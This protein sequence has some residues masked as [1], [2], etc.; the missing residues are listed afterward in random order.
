MLN[1][2]WKEGVVNEALALPYRRKTFTEIK[3]LAKL[4]QVTV[5]SGLRRAGKSTLMY[6]LIQDL[7]QSG[8]K[9]EKILYFSFDEKAESLL[10]LLK[11]YSDFT[12]VDWKKENCLLFLDEIQKL[13]DWSSKLK[14]IYDA[15]P[16]LK[17]IV[18]GSSSFQLEKEAKANLAGRHFVVDVEPLSFEEYLELKKS[19]IDLSKAN[20][21]EAEIIKEFNEYLLK[22]FPEIVDYTELSLVK[23]YIKDNVLEKVLRIDLPKKFRNVNEE[24]LT[25]LVDLFY[26]TPGMYLNYDELARDLRTS[27]KTLLQHVYYLQFAYV[28][29]I[30]KNY[31]PG[32]KTT[33]RKLQRAYPFHWSL[34]F[35]WA[36]KTSFETIAAS[37]LNAK[38]Y[39]R[40]NGKEVD[41]VIA[42]KAITPVEA[43]EAEKISS[44]DLKHLAYF[45]K[46]HSAKKALVV[47]NGRE[48]RRSLKGLEIT[49]LPLWKLSLSKKPFPR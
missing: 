2:W 18:S 36:G 24:L 16:N 1:P 11:A 33:S 30:V 3:K 5:I 27:K 29:R 10:D 25:R 32:A 48:E 12:K 9:P 8:A 14:A 43:K 21:W 38:Y 42:N 6:Q 44:S 41:F 22:P 47:Y 7:L 35:G 26:E 34:Q 37:F 4:R 40:K 46:K 13:V 19:P 28:L 45:M 17:I 15:F 39:W 20:L 23:T 31:R 49:K